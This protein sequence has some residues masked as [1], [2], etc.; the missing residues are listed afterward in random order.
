[1][2]STFDLSV[3]IPCLNE[4]HHLPKLWDQLQGQE[5]INLEI[6]LADGGSKDESLALA[7]ERG[8]A[9]C[10]TSPGRGC[11]MNQGVLLAKAP[12]FLFLHGDSEIR[13]PLLLSRALED[14]Q[15]RDR[16]CLAGHFG[17]KF[18]RKKV[19]C[20]MVCKVVYDK[21]YRYMEEKTFMNRPGT[22]HGD[23]GL[24]LHR[25]F[26]FELEGFD[27]S[28][29]FLE[30]QAIAEKIHQQGEWMTLP[31]IL[32]TSARRFESEGFFRRYTLMALMMGLYH[33]EMKRFF[34]VAP[35]VYR[36]QSQTTYLHIYPF[37]C[38]IGKLCKEL[39]W[40]RTLC[41]WYRVGRYV[42]GQFWQVFY[43][44]D[45]CLRPLYRKKHYPKQPYSKKHYPLV[46]FCDKI[47]APLMNHRMGD[48]IFTLLSY[49][50]FG[51]ILKTYFY[52]QDKG[53][54]N[55]NRESVRK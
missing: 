42:R 12:Y 14:F 34:E 27:E 39:G 26:F 55:E 8:I 37:Y 24:L 5:H 43:L 52:F 23:Q 18:I 44:L 41:L 38:V 4:A 32:Y 51:V 40:W 21:A 7:N 17:L 28:L 16:P 45:Q 54:Q 29:G 36:H 48:I 49:F 25:D 2:D 11:Q 3:I 19:A 30:D 13:D 50:F 47:L 46:E 22:T 6:I 20:K 15:K 53:S 35:K 10:V 33:G 9:F 1:M 31:G